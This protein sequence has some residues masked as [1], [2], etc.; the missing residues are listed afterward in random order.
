MNLINGQQTL[1][2]SR[3]IYVFCK[4]FDY[5]YINN[6]D[7]EVEIFGVTLH[8]PLLFL[9]C[10]LSVLLGLSALWNVLT[11]FNNH[12]NGKIEL[13]LFNCF[14]TL[15]FITVIMDRCI[16]YYIDFSGEMIILAETSVKVMTV[17]SF[18]SCSLIDIFT[19]FIIKLPYFIKQ[20]IVYLIGIVCV[21]LLLA[22]SQ[23]SILFFEI[24]YLISVYLPLT[25]GVVLFFISTISY[26]KEKL[27]L[28]ICFTIKT[29]V[30][31]CIHSLQVKRCLHWQQ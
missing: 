13:T 9:I 3:N 7:K 27:L 17:F 20:L 24:V 30:I 29:F 2:C 6:C 12:M 25:C 10:T 16:V 14:S 1:L 8:R 21:G 31:E 11:K 5:D 15:W 19:H 18:L 28:L 22:S 4:M 23:L 26:C